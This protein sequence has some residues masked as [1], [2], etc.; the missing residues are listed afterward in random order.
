V[1]TGGEARASPFDAPAV[2]STYEA[3]LAT[4]FGK[5]ALR[6]EMELLLELLG[7]DV[8]RTGTTLE[9]G[10]GTGLFAAGIA[11]RGGRVVGID[12]S[13]EMLRTARTRIP[14]CQADAGCLPFR[15]GA[16]DRVFLVAVLDFVDDPVA[17]LREA[18]RVSRGTV[19]VLA[20]ASGSWIAWRRRVRGA[21]GHPIFRRARFYPRRRLL[22]FAA[23]AGGCVE[24][25]RGIL[26]LPPALAARLPRIEERLSAGSNPF[27]S[28]VGLR[29]RRLETRASSADR[30][31]EGAPGSGGLDS[32]GRRS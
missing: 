9:I 19:A 1:N 6:L 18:V 20:L 8:G 27:A 29:M 25:V 22:A 30:G 31:H 28:L 15:N 10:T 11:A 3:W 14:V 13:R 12:A 16:F 7:E 4:P 21:L 5:L 24:H 32:A 23:Q 2:V 17:V 26:V